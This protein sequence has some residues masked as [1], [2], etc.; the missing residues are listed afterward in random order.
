MYQTDELYNRYKNYIPRTK[1][2]TLIIL[3]GHLLIEEQL[4]EFIEKLCN[5]PEILKDA[6]L[7]FYQKMCISKAI[8]GWSNK[9]FI[10]KFIEKL[11]NLR[12][13][14]SHS[15]EV[16]NLNDQIDHLLSIYWQSEFIKPENDQKRATVLR[17]TIGLTCAML[18]G[19]TVQYIEHITNKRL[20]M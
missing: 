15:L 20:T 19:Y 4:C 8:G 7:T 13:R 14:L 10:W 16:P 12:N 1:D 11:N 6:R 2:F 9:D 5:K 17:Q 18:K 3:K